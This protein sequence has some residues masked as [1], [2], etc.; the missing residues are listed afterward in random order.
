MIGGRPPLRTPIGTLPP[1]PHDAITDVPGVQ[2]GHATLIEG[3]GALRV[4]EGP[5]RTGVTVILPRAE[6][7][8]TRPL[9][10]GCHR[11]NGNGELTGLEWVR[12]S[13]LLTTPIA[14]TN[15]LSVGTVR[16][17]LIGWE[18]RRRPGEPV[19]W[20]LPVVGE[21]WDGV[22]NDIAGQHIRPE[23]VTAA[24]ESARG[25]PVAQ[26]SVGGGTGMI[27]H[28]FKGGIGSASRCVDAAGTR[29]TV[30]VLVQANHGRRARLT[31]G[32]RAIGARLSERVVPL[33]RDPDERPQGSGSIICVVATDA[34][35]VPEQCRRLAQ[36]A[37]L[38][39]GRTGG[40]GEHS[41][42]D[43]VLCFATGN[44]DLPED[45]D[46]GPDRVAWPVRMLDTRHIDRLFAAVV[47]AT[48]AAIV[49]ALLAAETMTGRDGITAHALPADLVAEALASD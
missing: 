39:I 35:L 1:G 45:P 24:L 10:A 7:A 18:V 6:P 37:A 25:G 28:G 9:F 17:A 23:H 13:G 29:I 12:E 5:I 8:F 11:L 30:G 48:E 27:C 34:P 49:A 32:G 31:I 21:T 2:V 43:M 46:P 15:T 36:R 47:E 44:P 33:P 38:G 42:G 4:G 20:S 16:D 14:L 3:A 41:S 22:L 40:L 19:R 26:G